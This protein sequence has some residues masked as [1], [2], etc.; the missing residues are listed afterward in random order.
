MTLEQGWAAE[1]ES[2]T[3]VASGW[4]LRRLF[5][6][7]SV[8]DVAWCLIIP[9]L[10]LSTDAIVDAIRIPAL[11]HVSV[12][13]FTARSISSISSTRSLGCIECQSLIRCFSCQN[14]TSH[15]GREDTVIRANPD[16]KNG[17]TCIT[18]RSC[19]KMLMPSHRTVSDREKLSMSR[20]RT[21]ATTKDHSMSLAPAGRIR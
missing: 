9:E 17:G 12:I 4:F 16:G 15:I 14:I 18:V 1:V 13:V 7:D 11:W 21:I 20:T 6:K 2:V 3:S 19:A 10:V 5:G 8:A